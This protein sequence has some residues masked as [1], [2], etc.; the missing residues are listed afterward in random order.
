M[1]FRIKRQRS[2]AGRLEQSVMRAIWKNWAIHNL[3]GHPFGE[4]A[5]WIFGEK[6]W[7][8]FHDGTLPADDA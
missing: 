2:S 6:G 3:I 4:I 1:T 5:S 8:F 7:I